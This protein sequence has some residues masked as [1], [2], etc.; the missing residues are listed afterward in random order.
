MKEITIMF[1]IP[2]EMDEFAKNFYQHYKVVDFVFIGDERFSKKWLKVKSKRTC[3]FCGRSMPDTSFG[4]LAHIVP[5]LIGNSS[6]YSDFE[7]DEC[8]QNFSKY[9][10]DL[11]NYIGFSRSINGIHSKKM[12]SGLVAKKL[13]IKSRTFVGENILVIAP[14]DVNRDGPTTSLR[15]TKNHYIPDHL[16]KSLLKSALSLLNLYMVQL[17]AIKL[18]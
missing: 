2:P 3:L 1:R 8:N 5:Q 14:E 12:A 10:N 15:Y 18:P 7:C 13:I 6:L 9:E 11:A 16:Y 4:N 17:K